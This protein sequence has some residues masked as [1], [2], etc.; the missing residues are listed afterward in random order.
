MLG[1]NL[2]EVRLRQSTLGIS[3]SVL[4]MFTH[5]LVSPLGY[6][7]SF[8]RN[9]QQT[10]PK[11][12]KKN[13]NQAKTFVTHLT[14]LAKAVLRSKACQRFVIALQVGEVSVIVGQNAIQD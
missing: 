11:C 5:L 6:R 13:Q 9:L 4:L 10:I 7:G 12:Q 1:S 8:R 2:V 14:K 3:K